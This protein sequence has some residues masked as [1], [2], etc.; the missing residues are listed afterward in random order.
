MFEENWKLLLGLFSGFLFGFL[1]QKG[2]VA[3]YE[4]ILGQLL[5]RDWTVLK[6][7]LT[8]IAVGAIGVYSM[9]G[10][11]WVS[12]HVKP[13]VLGG[14]VTGAVF[15]GIGMAVL[16]YCPGTTVAACGE[17]RRD[18]MVGVLGMLLGSS[19]YV[20]AYPLLRPLI[21]LGDH[22]QLTLPQ[23]SNI[24]ERFWIGAIILAVGIMWAIVGRQYEKTRQPPKSTQPGKPAHA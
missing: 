20:A 14:V 22:G 19:L 21:E 16:G 3:K 10:L 2:R 4:V 11:G 17:G 5:L 18:A 1:L 8:A 24:S 15:F 12:L 6:I 7:M 9:Y 13:L 23:I